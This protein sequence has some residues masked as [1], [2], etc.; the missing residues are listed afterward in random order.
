MRPPDPGAQWHLPEVPDL[1]LY[2]GL[3][4]PDLNYSIRSLPTRERQTD[5]FHWYIAIVP[6]ITRA[7][8]FELGSGMFINSSLPEAS[9]EFLRSV[10]VPEA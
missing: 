10:K 9:A 8:G 5:Y 6:R 3:G 4:N 2:H 1:R 7:A